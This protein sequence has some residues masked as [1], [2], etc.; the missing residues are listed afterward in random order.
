[1]IL[2]L[3]DFSFFLSSTFVYELILLKILW[4]PTMWRRKYVIKSSMTS[5]V[6]QDH[7]QWPFNLK[8]TF[9]SFYVIDWLKKQMPLNIMKEQSLTYTKTTFALYKDKI[10]FYIDDLRSNRTTLMLWR[11]CVAFLLSDLITTFL[12]TTFV[13]V[14]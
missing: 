4:M 8:L 12:W 3:W 10:M 2:W 13:L 11:V 1:M 6:I 9:S 7:K 5:K 14:F